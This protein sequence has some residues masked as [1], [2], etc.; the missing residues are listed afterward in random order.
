MLEDSTAFLESQPPKNACPHWLATYVCN[1]AGLFHLDPSDLS[2]PILF[3]HCGLK[4]ALF[5]Q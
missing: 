2:D 4:K 3:M 1:P 5:N